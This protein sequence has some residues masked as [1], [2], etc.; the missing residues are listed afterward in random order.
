MEASLI[1]S[2]LIT[3]QINERSI[4]RRLRMKLK[5]KKGLLKISIFEIL[6]SLTLGLIV[7]FLSGN[8]SAALIIVV[9][10]LFYSLASI[11]IYYQKL[12]R[13]DK[14]EYKIEEG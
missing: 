12:C 10:S 14:D 5:I 8:V 9:A 1:N 6:T 7:S 3:L 13:D 2:F 11:Y 4:H